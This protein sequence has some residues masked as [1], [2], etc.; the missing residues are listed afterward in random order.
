MSTEMYYNTI[1]F[2]TYYI[3]M[4]ILQRIDK[5]RIEKG[6][7]MYKLAEESNLP[8]STIIN[9]FSRKSLPSIQ[10]LMLI[11]DGLKISVSKFFAE[12]KEDKLETL[13]NEL[14][15]SFHL[16]KD[17]EKEAVILFIKKITER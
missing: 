11:C 3:N 15:E 2:L 1:S 7:S 9:M 12:T 10:T 14:L 8:T 6:W 17:N 13:D 4:D 5:L 16:L